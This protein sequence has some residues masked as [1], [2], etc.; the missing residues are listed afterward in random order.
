MTESNLKD[1]VGNPVFTSDRL[2]VS[3]PPGVV[4]GLAWT[5]MGGT[6]LYIESLAN[7]INEKHAR[8]SL[9]PTGQLGDVMKESTK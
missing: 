3:P 5:G 8:S 1:F 4:T 9:V 7:A 6:A 2:H